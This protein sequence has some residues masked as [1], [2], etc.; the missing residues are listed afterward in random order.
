MKFKTFNQV[1]SEY[2]QRN[3]K[4]YFS[5]KDVLTIRSDS[6]RQKEINV[7]LDTSNCQSFESLQR[8]SEKQSKMKNLLENHQNIN[9]VGVH[10]Q[11]I[12]DRNNNQSGQKPKS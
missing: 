10:S 6:K 3:K 12:L 8:P 5:I 11:K 2:L 7:I 4:L 9:T 1:F